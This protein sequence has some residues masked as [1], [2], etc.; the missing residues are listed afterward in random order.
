MGFLGKMGAAAYLTILMAR[1]RKPQLS[2]LWRSLSRLTFVYE[3]AHGRK[4][5]I[6]AYLPLLGRGNG[7]KEATHRPG[8]IG[9]GSTR[10]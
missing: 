2:C 4:E 7:N 10:H 3:E 9:T 1:G 5:A 8:D 6:E